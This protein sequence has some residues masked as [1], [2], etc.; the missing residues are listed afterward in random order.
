MN[1]KTITI[2]S[3]LLCLALLLV[4]DPQGQG[5][6]VVSPPNIKVVNE[7]VT[8]STRWVSLRTAATET[9]AAGY[10]WTSDNMVFYELVGNSNTAPA[11]V[12]D[13]IDATNGLI[14]VWDELGY[15]VNSVCIAFYSSGDGSPISAHDEEDTFDFEL[16]A[17]ADST[18]GPALPVYLTSSNGCAVGTGLCSY[19]PI[20]G[21]ALSYGR[22][23]DTISGTDSWPTGVTITDSGNNRI[24]CI[25]YDLMGCRYL[26]L[27]TFKSGGGDSEAHNVGAII[28]RF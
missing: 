6:Q 26:L 19:D 23:V 1:R 28:R 18:Y 9:A 27:R 15:G 24:A 4:L 10:D 16:V 7:L 5:Q 12:K 22:W 11:P 21:T 17:F 8:D 20:A 13:Y 2:I 14:D 25:H 3:I